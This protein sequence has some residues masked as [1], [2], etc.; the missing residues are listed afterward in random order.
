MDDITFEV[1]RA[2]LLHTAGIDTKALARANLARL[3]QT[4]WSTKFERYMRARLVMGALRYGT[5]AENDKP[6]NQDRWDVKTAIDKKVE[7]YEATGNTEHLVD[8]ANY[9]MLVF[10]RDPHPNKHFAASDAESFHCPQK[11][12]EYDWRAEAEAWRELCQSNSSLMPDTAGN[13]LIDNLAALFAQLRAQQTTTE[14]AKKHIVC[15]DS[16]VVLDSEMV[17]RS[18]AYFA[19]RHNAFPPTTP[20]L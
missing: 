19:H 7:A 20:P 3:E 17:K 18:N 1:I 9:L 11:A 10:I 13:L 8:A 15:A 16:G 6:G 4:E 5:L 2:R 12:P 14:P